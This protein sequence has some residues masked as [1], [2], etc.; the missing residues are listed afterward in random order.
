M[1]KPSS[2]A[3]IDIPIERDIFLR[4]LVRELAGTLEE[5]VGLE[6]ASGFISIVG[7]NLGEWMG[8]E[9]LKALNTESLTQE[10]VRD[11]LIDLKRRIKGDFYLVSEDDEKIILG[12]RKCPFGDK[13]RDRPS[14][15]MMTSNVFGTITAE[16]LGY[17]KVQ[18]QETISKGAE[19]CRVVVYKRQSEEAEQAEGREYFKS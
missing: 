6:E 8:A 11:V 13:V 19:Q 4:N 3:E 1:D 2:I 9:Y 5:V 18:L 17:A 10:Q 15:C 16:N 14:M 12:N 7:Q